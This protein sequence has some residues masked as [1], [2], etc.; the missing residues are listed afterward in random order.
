MLIKKKSNI[1]LPPLPLSG[2]TGEEHPSWA[3]C[4]WLL[5]IPA[6]PHTDALIP[7]NKENSPSL[8]CLQTSGSHAT[9]FRLK[10]KC[11]GLRNKAIHILLPATLVLMLQS[12]HPDTQHLI[13][14]WILQALSWLYAHDTSFICLL[15]VYLICSIVISLLHVCFTSET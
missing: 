9:A 3:Y 10:S 15:L 14:H 8:F 11:T 6:Y 1:S 5:T 4:T 7:Q 2:R 13:N 12:P